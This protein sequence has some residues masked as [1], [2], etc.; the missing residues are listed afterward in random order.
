[1]MTAGGAIESSDKFVERLY[2][3]GRQKLV[4]IAVMDL[5]S[6]G[7]SRWRRVMPEVSQAGLPASPHNWRWSLRAY[8]TA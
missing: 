7:F 2:S 3:L 1:M 5:D 4:D 8:Y 6:L